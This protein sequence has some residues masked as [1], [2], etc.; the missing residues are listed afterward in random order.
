MRQLTKTPWFGPKRIGWGFRP[1]TWQG[2]SLMVVLVALFTVARYALHTNAE[3]FLAVAALL[4]GFY[5]VVLV[6][7]GRPGRSGIIP[8]RG[9]PP[10]ER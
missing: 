6:T 5:V 9:R 4:A 10:A 1:I 2:W 8:G 3:F 7:G